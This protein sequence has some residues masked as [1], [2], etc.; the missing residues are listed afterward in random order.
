MSGI[1]IEVNLKL[2]EEKLIAE[3]DDNYKLP[4]LSIGDISTIWYYT[5]RNEGV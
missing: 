2:V 3:Q 1:F 4:V 5:Y